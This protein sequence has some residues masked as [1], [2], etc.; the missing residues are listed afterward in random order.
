MSSNSSMIDIL[1]ENID[2][3]DWYYISNNK[4]IFELDKKYIS[5][6]LLVYEEELMQRLFNP[7]R[8]YYYLEYYR[9]GSSFN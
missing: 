7:K 9:K 4:A 8:V 2:K 1:E 6:R 3:I 5:N